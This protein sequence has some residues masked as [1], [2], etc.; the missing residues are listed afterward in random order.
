MND[1]QATEII[2]RLAAD[3]GERVYMDIARWHLYLKDAHLDKILAQRLYAQAQQGILREDQALAIL[4][5]ILVDIG[6]GR[7]QI[8]LLDLV[9]VQGQLAYMDVVEDFQKRWT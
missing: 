8:P 1:S 6:G 4:R 3:L 5:E 7:R 2:E 9:P